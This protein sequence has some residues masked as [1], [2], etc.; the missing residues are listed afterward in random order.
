MGRWVWSIWSW[1]VVVAVAVHQSAPVAVEA[2][3]DCS[4]I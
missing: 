1:L 2:L 3:V 4:P